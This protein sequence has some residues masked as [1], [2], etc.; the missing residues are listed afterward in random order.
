MED[1]EVYKFNVGDI[2]RVN[3]TTGR[4]VHREYW[5]CTDDYGPD[6]LI[7]PLDPAVDWCGHCGKGPDCRGVDW[8]RED[9]IELVRT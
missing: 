4:V 2:V 9:M 3:G 6:Y 5:G 8:F 1:N 7:G